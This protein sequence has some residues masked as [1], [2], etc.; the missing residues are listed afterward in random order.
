MYF[1]NDD[2][3]VFKV[4]VYDLPCGRV[5]RLC[6]PSD[7]ET[8]EQEDTT[9]QRTPL[10]V[11]DLE[12]IKAANAW[13]KRQRER[14]SKT[15][16]RETEYSSSEEVINRFFHRN[17]AVQTHLMY[18]SLLSHLAILNNWRIGFGVYRK[19]LNK[20]GVTKVQANLKR[21]VQNH[22]S[23]VM[24]A[25]SI[26][27]GK[28]GYVYIYTVCTAED[29]LAVFDFNT[30]L[31]QYL[32][33]SHY[34][35]IECRPF[36]RDPYAFLDEHYCRELTRHTA[37]TT[38]QADELAHI[39]RS[40]FLLYSKE[41]T[42]KTNKAKERMESIVCIMPDEMARTEGEHELLNIGI[43]YMDGWMDDELFTEEDMEF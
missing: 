40:G 32:R 14:R 8:E 17:K 18:F 15:L 9:I 39:I 34:V 6:K 35:P 27:W 22:G 29:E 19:R 26:G 4:R 42:L 33:K 41:K 43:G 13:R 21:W 12:V 1:E 31:A 36:E 23:D 11:E 2:D 10:S 7:Y 28:N 3:D 38:L 30:L 5:V 25:V 24:G 37:L 20:D 16:L